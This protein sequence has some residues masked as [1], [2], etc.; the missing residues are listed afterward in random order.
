MELCR[1]EGMKGVGCRWQGNRVGRRE[2]CRLTTCIS[3][4]PPSIFFSSSSPPSLP[5]LS[6]QFVA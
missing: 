1:E 3:S 6:S 2:G 5:P 4:L